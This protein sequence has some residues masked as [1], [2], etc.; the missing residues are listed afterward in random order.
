MPAPTGSSTTGLSSIRI[1]FVRRSRTDG[2]GATRYDRSIPPLLLVESFNVYFH[3]GG[4]NPF[5]GTYGSCRHFSSPMTS[6]WRII[7][8]TRQVT[9]QGLMTW[10]DA[11]PPGIWPGPGVPT[12]PIFYPPGPSQGPGFPTHP[13]AP[14]GPPPGVWPGPGQPTPPIYYPPGP[15]QG[16]GFPTHPIA[17]G[18]PPPGIW[19]GPGVPTPPI[20]YPPG[21]WGPGSGFP[22]PPIAPGGPPPGIWP[23]PGQ[24]TP[25][26]F[27]PPG[28][29]P[30]P[31][32]PAHPIAPGGPPPGPSQGPGFPTHP[33]A[34]GGGGEGGSGGGVPAPPVGGIPMPGG[35]F[36]MYW[37]PVYGYVLAPAGGPGS[38]PI[39]TPH[40]APK[41]AEEE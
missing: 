6:Q 24:P 32:Y 23:G 16:P 3:T 40:Q 39:P 27:Y 13:I 14:G 41:E 15:S 35:V 26:I 12:P 37:S 36:V 38:M 28:I 11:A 7:M 18:G 21:I 31:G 17:P 29:W 5:S 25:P 19:P 4:R 20:F 1:E 34:P 33:I 10:E 9:I 30:S 8:P 22:T 2:R